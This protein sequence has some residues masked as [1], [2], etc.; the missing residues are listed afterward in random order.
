MADPS[1]LRIALV[2]GTSG[3]GVGRHV[4]ALTAGLV[5]AGHDVLVVGPAATETTFGFAAAG[6]TFR[7]W[8]VSDRPRP[9]ADLVAVQRLRG[10]LGGADVVHAHGLRAGGLTVLALRTRRAR[11]ALVVTLHNA[12]LAG[13][14]VAL[15]YRA[16]ERL[17]ARGA[18]VVLAVSADLEHRM[19]ELGA[20]QVGHAVVPAPIGHRSTRDPATTRSELGAEGPLVVTVGRLAE[21]KGLPLLLDAAA[22]LGERVPS[23]L[24]VVAGDGPL[25]ERLRRR[26][27]DEDLPVRLLGRRDDIA[28]LL[29]AA[30][31][32]VVPSSWEGQPLVVQEALRAGAPMVATAVGGIPDLVGDAAVLVP[33]GDPAALADAI[34]ALLDDPAGRGW[35]AATARAR[36]AELPD[37]ADAV[38][39]ALAV[40]GPLC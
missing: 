33:Y 18:A 37:D 13:G 38:D 3:G 20:R 23:P 10:L 7:A 25:Q 28:D 8:E 36:A 39:A 40:Y 17:V 16:L 14:A 34:S 5:G 29:S 21:Q 27:A 9:G 19:R 32:V 26:I 1:R 15:A 22:R 2:L 6:A 35:L 24:F 12:L 4:A 30:D 31:V 11:P